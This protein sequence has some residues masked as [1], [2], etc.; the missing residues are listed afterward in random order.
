MLGIPA[1]QSR[2]LKELQLLERDGPVEG[3]QCL[4]GDTFA[5]D[6]TRSLLL[7]IEGPPK[8]PYYGHHYTLAIQFPA[9][10]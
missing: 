8:S 5:L 10:Y 7:G 3:I 1:H 9:Q 4:N 6:Q 2:I